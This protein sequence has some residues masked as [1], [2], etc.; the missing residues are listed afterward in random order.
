MY[1]LLDVA[2]GAE[3]TFTMM[4]ERWRKNDRTCSHSS[5]SDISPI[6]TSLKPS[7]NIPASSDAVD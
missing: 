2:S 6:V 4:V 5:S 7:S 3:P 1:V